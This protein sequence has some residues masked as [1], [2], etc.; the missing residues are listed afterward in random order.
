MFTVTSHTTI[1]AT[2]QIFI[3][4]LCGYAL[5]RRGLMDERGL[6]LLSKLLINLFFPALIFSQLVANF[7]FGRFPNWW[8]F[9]LAGWGIVA[10]GYVLGS[11]VLLLDRGLSQRNEFRALVSFQ[12]SGFIPLLI[13]ASLP[14]KEQ[15]DLL[16]VTIFLFIIGFDTCLWTMAVWLLTKSSGG[17]MEWKRLF[18]PPILTLLSTL[19]LIATGWHKHLGVVMLKPVQMWG[20]CALPLAMIIVGGNLAMTKITQVRWGEV[21]AISLTKLI[22]F[23]LLAIILIVAFRI[24]QP[25]ALLLMIQ[26]CMPSAVTLSV[27]C[28]HHKTPNAPF[29]NQ[30]IFFT[31]VF[32]ILTMPLFLSAGAKLF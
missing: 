7:D 2:A 32:S 16:T 18:N 5:F 12:N 30:G 25:L 15:S 29:I 19:L 9:P 10:C 4:G 14:V 13:A 23:P 27:I 22:V 1:T 6:T 26:A 31:H 20:N 28:Q 17:K 21:F 24:P 3:L 11:L 8:V